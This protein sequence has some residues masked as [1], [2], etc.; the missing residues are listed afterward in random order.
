MKSGTF[1]QDLDAHQP[2]RGG[3]LVPAGAGWMEGSPLR[4]GV[5]PSTF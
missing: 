1:V 4:D 5:N 2:R 3:G